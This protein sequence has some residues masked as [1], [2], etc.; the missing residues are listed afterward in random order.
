MKN[1]RVIRGR[2]Y[3]VGFKPSFPRRRESM[4]SPLPRGRRKRHGSSND[5]WIPACAGT[6]DLG[7]QL[8]NSRAWG[9]GCFHIKRSL[10]ISGCLC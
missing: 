4:L 9:R 6:T 2:F 1:G 3:I 10:T 5:L 7:K 8:K